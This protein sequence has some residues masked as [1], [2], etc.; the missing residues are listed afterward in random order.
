MGID[1]FA[2]RLL[3]G[4]DAVSTPLMGQTVQQGR[5]GFTLFKKTCPIR[6]S[7]AVTGVVTQVN[8]AIEKD[9]GRAVA[10]PYTDGWVCMGHCPD[11]KKDLKQLFFM[12]ER[13]AFMAGRVRTLHEML[14]ESTRMEAADG[15]DPVF[16]ILNHVPAGL[17]DRLIRSFLDPG[18]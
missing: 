14:E 18:H 3:G 15:G 6:F 13:I 2:A 5:A 16:G 8:P 17:R 10:A 7:S 9:P 11:L 4:I 12:E 1:D